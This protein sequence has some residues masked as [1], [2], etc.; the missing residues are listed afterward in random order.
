MKKMMIL[1]DTG[2]VGKALVEKFHEDYELIGLSRSIDL[3]DYKHITFDLETDDITYYL[4]Q[5]K[6]HIFISCTRGDFAAQLKCHQDII[7]YGKVN[8]M[9]L[10]YYSTANVFD[11]DPSQVKTELSLV[12]PSSAYGVFKAECEVLV[13]GMRDSSIIRLPVVMSKNSPRM[14][15]IK[16]AGKNKIKIFHKLFLTAITSHQVAE[17]HEEIIENRL[18]GI[19]HFATNDIMEQKTFYELLIDDKDNLIIEELDDYYLAII[20]TREDIKH[21]YYMS[22]VINEL[23]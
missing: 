5:Y 20:P 18:K 8:E 4:N 17:L 19:F 23:T 12:K 1:G 7:D 14:D 9:M 13:G 10:Y 15:Q 2:L 6:P 22:D 16:N 11:G 21:Q 3:F